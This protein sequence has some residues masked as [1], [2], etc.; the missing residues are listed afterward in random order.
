MGTRNPHVWHLR[1]FT[2]LLRKGKSIIW[3]ILTQSLTKRFTW[4][5]EKTGHYEN[6]FKADNHTEVKDK[7]AEKSANIY[8]A[9]MGQ[10]VFFSNKKAPLEYDAFF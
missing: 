3:L 9:K 8:W 5:F 10:G 2:I 4:Y 6:A 1:G 7:L